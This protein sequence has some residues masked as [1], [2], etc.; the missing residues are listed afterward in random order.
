MSNWI[1]VKDRLPKYK[2]SYLV[3]VKM[4]WQETRVVRFCPTVGFYSNGTVT[5]WQPLPEPP[6][7]EVNDD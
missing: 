5:H 4:P 3:F 1:S 2:D 7:S 6:I